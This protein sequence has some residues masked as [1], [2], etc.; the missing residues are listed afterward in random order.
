MNPST[1]WIGGILA[2]TLNGIQVHCTPEETAQFN[3]PHNQTCQEYAGAFA[4]AAGGYLLN[5]QATSDCEYCPFRDGNEY[6]KTLNIKADD[7]WRS[8]SAYVH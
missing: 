3:T 5:P 4:Q 8:K 2:A 1:Y 6:L 7:K